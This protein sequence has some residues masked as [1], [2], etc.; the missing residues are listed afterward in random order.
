MEEFDRLF[1]EY[2][3]EDKENKRKFLNGE[4]N[5]DN[6][7]YLAF[8]CYVIRSLENNKKFEQVNN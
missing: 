1:D 4:G 2:L 5:L 6:K 7:C 3:K 8:V